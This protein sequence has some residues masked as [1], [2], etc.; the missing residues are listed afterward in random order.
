MI[1]G[2]FDGVSVYELAVLVVVELDIL[3]LAE[4]LEGVVATLRLAVRD[5]G[6]HEV[7]DGDED[8]EDP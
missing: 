5:A 2:L 4:R 8:Q 1:S 6:T 7:P 3:S